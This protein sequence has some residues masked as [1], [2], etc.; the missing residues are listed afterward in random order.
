[1]HRRANA[2]CTVSL[3]AETT[4]FPTSSCKTSEL[5]MFHCR[6]CEPVQSGVITNGVM[7]RVNKNHLIVLVRRILIHPVR[8]EHTQVT[9]LSTSPL[10]S[11]RTLVALELQLRNTLVLGFTVLDTLLDGTLA[12]TTAN[13]DCYAQFT[14]VSNPFVRIMAG[15]QLNGF[16]WLQ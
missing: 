8:V 3:D 4:M 11:D 12:T 1:M 16:T 13:A 6:A 15:S 10:F 5:T 14:K 9:A 7:V 2:V